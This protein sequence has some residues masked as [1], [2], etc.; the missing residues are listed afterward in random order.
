MNRSS[1][2]PN[3]TRSSPRSQ[4][5]KAANKASAESLHS[6]AQKPTQLKKA[7]VNRRNQRSDAGIEEASL[8]KGKTGTSRD[9]RKE[10]KIEQGKENGQKVD[11][12]P[13]TTPKSS[14]QKRKAG[15]TE[16]DAILEGT[17]P[18]S[19]KRW[20]PTKI[21][22]EKLADISPPPKRSKPEKTKE[23]KKEEAS[24]A[25]VS[26]SKT[27]RKIKAKKEE[28][29]GKEQD[30]VD[31][32]EAPKKTR[33]PRKTKEEKE[34]EAMPLATRTPNL[35]LYIGAHVSS[36]K[37]VQNSITNAVHIGANALALFLKSQ[38]K[39]DNPPLV[40]SHRDQFISACASHG[41]DPGAHI[42]PHGSYLVNLAQADPTKATQAY[43]GFIDDLHRCEA[44]GI[45]LY[46]FHPGSTGPFPRPS[47][48]ARI[49]AAL[50]RA[51]A[52]TSTVIPVL[53]TMAGAGNVIGSTFEDLRD[54]IA[55]VE[56]KERIGVCL[57]TCHVFAAGYD[58]RSPAAFEATMSNFDKVV[59]LRY[60]RA[61]H[62][63]DSKAPLGSHRDLQ[64]VS[65]LSLPPC[66]ES[67]PRAVAH[68]A[69]GP[70]PKA[71]LNPP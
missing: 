28:K 23:F 6:A 66:F 33:R 68:T 19:S 25:A 42:L 52:E 57:D 30:E 50:N 26:P 35:P 43:N 17:T 5:R 54:I 13:T 16:E 8:S 37:G 56:Q 67:K 40:P 15:N 14:R 7:Q 29:E 70:P 48:I 51:H 24:S 69:A 58:I 65:S 55:L 53:E 3:T 12:A 32:N 41:Y 38:R 2:L 63:N 31:D 10:P 22:R 34:A 27:K 1:N 64:Y 71:I 11:F 20:K 21:E 61:L 46:N 44:L 39:W 60:L 59:G 9:S 49:A 4:T 62:L 47:A 36:A 45:R 18:Q